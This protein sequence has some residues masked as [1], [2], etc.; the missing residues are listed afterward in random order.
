MK[1]IAVIPNYT[2]DTEYKYTKRLL[3]YLDGKAQVLMQEKDRID[4]VCAVF[5]N[6]NVFEGCD[7]AIVLGGDG[8]I[9]EV[10]EH[11][12]MR[13]IPIMGILFMWN[14]RDVAGMLVL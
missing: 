12:G 8:T 5:V 6:G 9:L 10:A 13:N 1:K 4:G 3:T 14:V 7:A 2:K 11:C